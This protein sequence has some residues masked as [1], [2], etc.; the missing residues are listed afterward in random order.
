MPK[1]YDKIIRENI[2]EVILPLAYK[3]LN[4]R[5]KRLEEIPDD[6][7][8]TIEREPDFLKKVTD[9]DDNLFILQIEFQVA[10]ETDMVLRMCEYKGILLRKHKLP[11]RQFV[12]YLGRQDPKMKTK[13]QDVIPGDALAYDFPLI[14]IHQ[15]DYQKL[16]ASDIPEEIIL[17]ILSDFQNESPEI[18]VEKIL[19]R[20]AA[21]SGDTIKLLKYLK[22]LS[23]LSRLRNLEEITI[24]KAKAMTLNYD[25]EQDFWYQEGIEKGIEKGMEKGEE[26]EKTA[27]ILRLLKS[28]KLTLEE[29]ASVAEVS[30]D[31][32]RQLQA[33]P[34]K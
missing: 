16:L 31:Y 4:I 26:K 21:M 32:V 19:A 7:Q 20:V 28:D 13:L 24:K 15:Y 34:G 27:I 23:V 22:Q 29:I 10:D 14:N 18:V 5:P 6:L 1:E 2:E 17:A 12:I 3:L 25:V 33:G 8:T 11:V 9:Q 30:V